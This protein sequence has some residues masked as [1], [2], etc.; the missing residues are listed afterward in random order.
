MFQNL[1]L[2]E[3]ISRNGLILY[4]II[5]LVYFFTLAPGVLQI[6]SGEL[7]AVQY[8]FGISHPT[9]YPLFS[10]LGYLWSLLN[11]GLRPIY[12]LNI[13]SM[14]L[15]LK[16]VYLF[17]LTAQTLFSNLKTNNSSTKP[18]LFGLSLVEV[19]AIVA[20]LFLAFSRTFW[21]NSTGVE[22]YSLQMAIFTFILYNA[23][24]LTFNY[25]EKNA[26]WLA[27]SVALGFSNHLTTLLVLPGLIY[28]HFQYHGITK[29]SLTTL[30]KPLLVGGSIILAMYGLLFWRATFQ[31]ILNWG[32]ISSGWDAFY[33]HISGWQYRTWMFSSDAAVKNL[34]F[35]F[36]GLPYQFTWLGLIMSIVG[37]YYLFT[38]SRS[39]AYFIIIN[40]IFATMYVVYYDINDLDSYFIYTYINMGFCL[41]ASVLMAFEKLEFLKPYLHQSIVLVLIG[42]FPVYKNLKSVS[43]R[44]VYLYDDYTVE[45][46]NSLEPNAILISVQWDVLIAP[47]LYYQF[48][49]N[50]RRDV[51]V[52]DKELLRRS[53]YFN[54]LRIWDNL[55]VEKVEQEIA[56]FLKSL[57]P[58]EKGGRFDP[59]LLQANFTRLIA[60]FLIK[61]YDE[62]PIYLAPEIIDNDFGRG[63]DVQLPASY[64][65]V[66]QSYFYRVYKDADYKALESSIKENIRY[67]SRVNYYTR[68]IKSVRTR[69]L[70]ARARYEKQ[71]G[72]ED[73]KSK[74]LEVITTNY[75]DYNIPPDLY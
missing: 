1:K 11:P 75:P 58:F 45:A 40:L 46:L 54:Q 67:P 15:S 26:M 65:L 32:D 30:V 16:A 24:N 10:M 60:N 19:A 18:G 25:S 68:L 48:V 63:K 3:M 43:Q 56:D 7:A 49:E 44:D 22:V 66:P 55:A 39:I 57:E 62:R 59:N 69:M 14:L 20:T 31:P 23:L 73:E 70:V 71:F 17:Y 21:I 6:D 52:V 8:N 51:L 33:R 38:K 74:I 5:A 64:S 34:K 2:K 27:I 37:V 35:F 12:W 53:W 4:A 9:G 13:L 47:S 42:I 29:K 41:G 36:N 50:F 61:N 72:K 28:L